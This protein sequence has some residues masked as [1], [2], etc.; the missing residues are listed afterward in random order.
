MYRDVPPVSG[1]TQQE[2]AE[3]EL[4]TDQTE[5]WVLFDDDTFYVSLRCWS[6][7][8]ARII[9]NEIKRDGR[10]IFG[11]ETIAVLI[12]TFLD[13]R[14]G[15]EFKTNLLGGIFDATV[16]NEQTSNRDWNGVWNVRASRFE[17]GWSVEM[18]I[19]FKTLRF[20]PGGTQ[21]WGLNVQRRVAAKNEISF[22]A[23]IPR[24]LSYMGMLSL[25]HI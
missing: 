5:V 10:G 21:R 7:A 4:A 16:A 19:P 2:P 15:D 24:A 12:D 3:G 8:P 13:R 17:E 23:P 18:A 25:I 1:F 6:E 14:N 9:A 20:R 22:L 11:N